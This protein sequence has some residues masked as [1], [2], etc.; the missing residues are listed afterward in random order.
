M[1]EVR[2]F[3]R[4]APFA[5]LGVLLAL[6]P[7]RAEQA[8]RIDQVLDAIV[9]NESKLAG[10]LESYHPLVETYIQTLAPDA[11]LGYTPVRDNYFFGRMQLTPS[12][13]VAAEKKSKESRKAPKRTLSL[14]EEFH[15]AIFKP[16]SFGR[17]LVLDRGAFDRQ[18][19]EF[20]FVRAE[21]L[22]EVRTLV[23]DVTPKSGAA[24]DRLGSD[25]FTGRIWVDDQG[26]Q[27]VRYNGIYSSVMVPGMHF[28]SWRLNMA[29]GLWL[30]AYVYTEEPDRASKQLEYMHKGQTRIWGYAIERPDADDEFT[31][32]LI[33][34]PETRDAS[35]QPGQI[36][37]V[38]SA[39]SWENEAEQNVVRRLERAGL[40]A[41]S[42]ELDRVLETVVTNLE[43]TNSLDIQPPV[44]C[45]VLLTTPLESFTLGHTIVL[46]RGL[47]DVLPN[48]A[49]LA[50]MLAHELGHI[51]GGHRLDTRYAFSD[52]MLVGD[53]QA[54]QQFDFQRNPV[55]EQEADAKAFDLLAASPYKNELGNAGLFLKALAA[56][57]ERLPAL[58]RPHF[59]TKM[60]N[61]QMAYRLPRLVELAPE[62]DPGAV[63]QIAALPLGGRVKLD[64]WNAR[65]EL[66]KNNRVALMSAREKMPFQVTPLVPYL[67]RIGAKTPGG[68]EAVAERGKPAPRP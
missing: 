47:I 39:R 18:H 45:R 58:I 54:M 1:R 42:G 62:L 13:P 63:A 64:P 65:V 8:S 41:P 17:M 22:A 24:L 6:R 11:A 56:S 21:F 33:D 32:V 9:A 23:F 35:E 60:A 38:E 40:L 14:F 19:Y 67:A 51:L 52:Q 5:A 28:D 57:A 53:G 25:R 36:S 37:P 30:P 2:S 46:S 44:H 15:S 34:A 50:M 27:I 48:E 10:T 55:E 68:V 20:E 7:I 16:E 61:G 49:S 29:P 26:Y 66:M 43:V 59:G 12:A 3:R 31:K 4:W